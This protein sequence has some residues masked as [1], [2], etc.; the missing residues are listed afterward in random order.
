M[1][2][3][4]RIILTPGNPAPFESW[5]CRIP[6]SGQCGVIAGG[7]EGALR[8]A[9]HGTRR[10]ALLVSIPCAGWLGLLP[11]RARG[12]HPAEAAKFSAVDVVAVR[13]RLDRAA[14]WRSA[15]ARCRAWWTS[16]G[17]RIPGAWQ[18]AP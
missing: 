3:H 11:L 17:E 16:L 1:P 12:V 7:L 10:H 6:A 13:R 15:P 18:V 14:R 4:L 8:V 9:L 5:R 2:S